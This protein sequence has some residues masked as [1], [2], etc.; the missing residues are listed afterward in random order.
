MDYYGWHG[1]GCSGVVAMTLGLTASNICELLWRGWGFWEVFER[2]QSWQM[3]RN[4]WFLNLHRM[5]HFLFL[6]IGKDFILEKDLR[7][8][9]E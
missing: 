5:Q 4:E 1:A 9:L 7:F 8:E 6:Q 3:L 2:E